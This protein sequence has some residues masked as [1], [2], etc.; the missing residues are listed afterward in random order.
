MSD[1]YRLACRF[2]GADDLAEIGTTTYASG[3]TAITT[4]GS[5]AKAG[6]FIGNPE[7]DYEGYTDYEG[8]EADMTPTLVICRSIEPL[9]G[10]CGLTI[11][12][13]EGDGWRLTDAAALVAAP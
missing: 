7:F 9:D 6:Q 12:E 11:A 4:P 1:K 10:Y 5:Q 13:Y 3:L 8:Y 2:H